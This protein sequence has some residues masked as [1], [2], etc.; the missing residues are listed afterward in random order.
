MGPDAMNFWPVC[1]PYTSDLTQTHRNLAVCIT[2]LAPVS[3]AQLCQCYC[4][5]L[6]FSV[7]VEGV[8]ACVCVCIRVC[9]C[10]CVCV[11]SLA[12]LFPFYKCVFFCMT[13]VYNIP[14][15]KVKQKCSQ[16][17]RHLF[18]FTTVPLLL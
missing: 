10:V 4:L 11:W 8:R 5:H 15:G 17:P 9:V 12:Q 13:S 18:P 14:L 2:I 3:V 7:C 16:F 1:H 6:L